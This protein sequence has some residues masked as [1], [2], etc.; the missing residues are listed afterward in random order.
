[1]QTLMIFWSSW[2]LEM[3][4][5]E[6]QQMVCRLLVKT[7]T[8][9]W[10]NK[11]SGNDKSDPDCCTSSAFGLTRQ[12]SDLTPLRGASLLSSSSSASVWRSLWTRLF[13]DLVKP[14]GHHRGWS[15]LSWRSTL[16]GYLRCGYSSGI[17]A[18]AAC[19]MLTLTNDHFQASTWSENHENLHFLHASLSNKVPKPHF[20][21]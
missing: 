19:S 8:K 17:L 5:S 21:F 11:C 4:I 20:T 13:C 1:M 6:H 14:L 2:R 7:S 3:V 18:A 10:S 12:T 9:C 15:M 16:S